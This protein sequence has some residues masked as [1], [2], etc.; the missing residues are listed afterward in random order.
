MACLQQFLLLPT[1]FCVLRSWGFFW[2]GGRVGVQCVV[3]AVT[4]KEKEKQIN[5]VR[6]QEKRVSRRSECALEGQMRRP[7]GAA[8][9]PKPDALVSAAESVA[10]NG[11]EGQS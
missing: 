1:A 7:G 8:A 2:G 3:E 10:R 5:C 6:A 9:S 4:G 11:S